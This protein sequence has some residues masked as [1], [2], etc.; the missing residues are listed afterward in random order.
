MATVLILGDSNFRNTL[1]K[2]GER[3]SASVGEKIKFV[4]CATNEFLKAEL[5]K[6]DATIKSR[7][8]TSS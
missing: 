4:G 6:T 8:R 2:N 7:N 1:E 3:L 5:E